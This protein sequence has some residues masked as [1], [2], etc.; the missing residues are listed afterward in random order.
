MSLF[1]L[2]ASIRIDGSHSREIADIAEQEWQKAH[3]TGNVIRR[4][5]GSHPLPV[6]AWT[7]AAFA[8][9]VPEEDR[10]PAQRDAVSLAATLTDELAT[11]DSYLLAVPL[12]NFGVPAPLKTWVDLVITD[13]RMAP[14]AE[15]VTAGK[16]AVLVVVRGGGYGP[17]TPR[18][19][20]DHSI[21]WI[22]RIL[23]DVWQTDLQVIES[24][25]TLAAV[26]P[27]L[28]EFKDLAAELRAT[29]EDQARTHGRTLAGATA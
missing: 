13:P 15:P 28:A 6:E 23:S 8:G 10:S 22:R 4:D 2:D 5:V 21:G 27:A 26:A 16:P 1:R 14:G 19:G 25:F 20:W 3:P 24:E 11:A 17:G 7:L 9:Y 12:Y 18:D 29:A